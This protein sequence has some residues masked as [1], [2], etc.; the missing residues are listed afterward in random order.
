MQP[1]SLGFTLF[2]L[3]LVL[4]IISLV[5]AGVSIAIGSASSAQKQ[6]Q[7]EGS[8]L[9]SKM[10]FALDESLMQQRV[11]GLQVSK[12]KE[13]PSAYQFLFYDEQLENKGWSYLSQPL[14]SEKFPEDVV[15]D[16]Q[17]DSELLD[18]LSVDSLNN[19]DNREALVPQIV[20][21][22]SGDVSDFDIYLTIKNN[23]Q[24][25]YHIF[26]NERGV[27]DFSLDGE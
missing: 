7:G 25:Q 9:I 4:L 3:L 20:F 13:E 26:V 5:S 14:A 17:V 23:K 10:R 21:Y 6:L 2:E 18:A 27:I 1:R 8:K 12:N 24:Y 19:I 22:P 15:V 16:I 11:V